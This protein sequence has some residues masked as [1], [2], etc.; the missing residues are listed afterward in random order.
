MVLD[1]GSTQGL[2]AIQCCSCLALGYASQHILSRSVS[3]E[4]GRAVGRKGSRH[5]NSLGCMAVLTLA[6][7]CVAAASLLWS[8]GERRE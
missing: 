7:I 3:P 4:I 8:Y 2:S 5:K 6:L 1:A